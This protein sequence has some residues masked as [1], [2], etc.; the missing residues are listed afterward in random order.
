M[1]CTALAGPVPRL[2]RD[3]LEAQCSRRTHG[4][5]G[6]AGHVPDGEAGSGAGR[7]GEEEDREGLHL[8]LAFF[9]DERVVR[10]ALMAYFFFG[11]RL[12]RTALTARFKSLRLM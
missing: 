3:A 4:G 10:F 12:D 5:L 1:S 7:Q 2:N 11:V 8:R 9:F 6:S